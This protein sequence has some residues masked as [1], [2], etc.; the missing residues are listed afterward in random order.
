MEPGPLFDPTEPNAALEAASAAHIDGKKVE[1]L[2]VACGYPQCG[3][4]KCLAISRGEKWSSRTGP[5]TCWKS[6]YS[7]SGRRPKHKDHEHDD[8]WAARV[9]AW[10]AVGVGDVPV[11]REGFYTFDF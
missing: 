7:S 11:F 6:A 1:M 10:A 3:C 8:E 4:A 9:D 5:H 2:C